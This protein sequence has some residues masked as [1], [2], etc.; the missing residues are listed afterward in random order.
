MNVMIMRMSVLSVL[1][2]TPYLLACQP[3]KHSAAQVSSSSRVMKITFDLGKI[4]T[5]GLV[6]TAGSLRS[7]SYE[8]CIPVNE[9]RLAEV[10]AIDLSVQISRSPGRIGCT[11][12]HYLVIGHTHQARWRDV[13]M[14]IARLDYVQRIDEFVGE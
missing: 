11:K 6:G 10:R 2:A 8:F 4:S 7:L 12:D 3:L 1:T 9:K 5:E 13:L 14:A